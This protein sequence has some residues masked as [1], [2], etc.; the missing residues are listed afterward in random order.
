MRELRSARLIL[1]PGWSG[2]AL[3]GLLMP[4]VVGLALATGVNLVREGL[5]ATARTTIQL[6]GVGFV[7]NWVFALD[8]WLGI[9]GVLCA[10]ALLAGWT[11][12]R[13]VERA[14]QGTGPAL[15]VILALT[16]ALTLIW[17]TQAVVGIHEPDAR[18]FIPLGG[19]ILGNAMTAGALAGQRFHDELRDGRAT[20]EAALSLGATPAQATQ[21]PLRRSLAAAMTP[22][23]NAMMIVGIVKLPGVMTGQMLGGSAPLEAAKYQIVV[24]FMLAFADGV[25]AL[26]LL[27]ILRKMAF[28]EAWQPRL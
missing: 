28:T 10:M 7:L 24:M 23:L 19:I 14:L 8:A 5:I 22:T 27:R 9:V 4:C 20:I 6:L 15:T 17:V 11:G 26:L 13:R 16:T 12:S 25:T 3:A 2:L 18:Y 1:D 21:E